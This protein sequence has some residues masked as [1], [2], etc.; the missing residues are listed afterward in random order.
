MRMRS[1]AKAMARWNVDSPRTPEPRGRVDEDRGPFPERISRH[2]VKSGENR[3]SRREGACARMEMGTVAPSNGHGRHLPFPG[4][5]DEWVADDGAHAAALRAAGVTFPPA[6][7]CPRRT[8]SCPATRS[9]GPFWPPGDGGGAGS[10]PA[11]SR[12]AR[13][14]ERHLHR[15]LPH[16]RRGEDAPERVTGCPGF[17]Q[18]RVGTR[19]PGVR[20][21]V[22]HRGAYGVL[23]VLE[24]NLREP[25]AAMYVMAARAAMRRLLSGPLE[26]ASPGRDRNKP[27]RVS[28]RGGLLDGLLCVSV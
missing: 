12:P 21:R 5:W 2:P 25:A 15:R 20:P 13:L 6:P 9:P 11:R 27:P 24:D 7:A 8:A 4:S 17:E 28:T 10:H 23:R 18:A 22:G 1:A 26:S 19:R 16:R 3:C 14:P